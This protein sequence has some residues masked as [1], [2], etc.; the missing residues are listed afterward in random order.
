MYEVEDQ[1]IFINEYQKI[2]RGVLCEHSKSVQ[3][4]RINHNI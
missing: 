3:Q 1:Q 4:Q 2:S